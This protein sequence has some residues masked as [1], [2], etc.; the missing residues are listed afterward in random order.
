MEIEFGIMKNSNIKAGGLYFVGNLFNKAIA[1]LT[2][3]IFTHLL[4]TTEYGI[5]S[6]Y[7]SWVTILSA[8]VTLSLGNSIRTAYVD[9]K[10]DLN[11][12]ISSVLVLSLLIFSG[13]SVMIIIIAWFYAPDVNFMLVIF[14]LVQSFMNCIITMYTIRYMMERSYVKKT[15]LLALPNLSVVILS[16]IF[17][18][19][20]ND[21]KHIGRIFSYVLIYT[22]VGFC[23]LFVSF[24]KGKKLVCKQ[25]WNYAFKISLPLVFH[26]LSVVL[27]A[28]ADRTM[29][30]ALYNVSETGI[31]SLVY[32]FSMIATVATT[33]MESVWVPW[34]TEKLQAG[35]KSSVNKN[36]KLYMEIVV[37]FVFGIMLVAPEILTILAPEEYWSGKYL[38]PPIVMASFLMF[39]YSISVDLEYYYKSTKIIAKNTIWAAVINIVLNYIFIPQY[40]AIAAAYTTLISYLISFGIH[41]RAARNLDSELFPFKFYIMPLVAVI[42]GVIITYLL[43]DFGAIRWCVAFVG[44]ALYMMFA[45]KNNRFGVFGKS[46]KGK[47]VCI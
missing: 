42:T 18:S 30:S 15:M 40:G 38:I 37:V 2:I 17:I 9:F 14:C 28:Q 26:G 5:V 10:D 27:L 3:P 32:N 29:I 39:L 43:M 11:S 35:D 25:Y 12:Y 34:F 47:G 7:I 13:C 44:A 45:I 41:Y 6:T 22:V 23:Y 31:Y 4:T 1:F 21:N 24:A 16:I 19:L 8:V 20:M 46:Q 36:V 33:S